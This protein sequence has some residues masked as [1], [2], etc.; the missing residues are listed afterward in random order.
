MGLRYVLSFVVI[1][2]LSTT[3]YGQD[4]GNKFAQ[5]IN[6]F[7]VDW[8]KIL[9][10]E[11]E[12]N[13]L[14]SPVSVGA[15]L[16]IIQQGAKGNSAT[17]LE[18]TL[19]LTGEESQAGFREL[20]TNLKREK[21]RVELEWGSGGYIK[22]DYTVNEE[23]KENVLKNFGVQINDQFPDA[24]EAAA[25]MNEEISNITRG[26][27]KDLFT[28]SN[29]K[30]AAALF[31]NAIYF[32]GKWKSPFP[33]SHTEDNKFY[34]TADNTIDVPF[35]EQTLRTRYGEDS[36][37]GVKW[38]EL[39]YDDREYSMTIILPTERH[40]LNAVINKITDS[41]VTNI[42]NK[43]DKERVYLKMPKFTLSQKESVVGSLKQLGITDIFS[44]QSDL[45]GITST[46]PPLVVSDIIQQVNVDV[47][48]DGSTAA[49]AV[50][51]VVFPLSFEVN[52]DQP[53][54]F[55]I[56]EP[57]L[58]IISQKSDNIPLFVGKVVKPKV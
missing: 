7:T 37:L 35:M 13:V 30:E 4:A 18:S 23:F 42:L 21:F 52:P 19:H 40:G 55:K 45:T 34:V 50:G 3:G 46:T 49:A 32:K 5:S 12:E 6:K 29:L 28:P 44:P 16:G 20:T 48:E 26:V 14:I 54:E 22:K 57:F 2:C 43:Q 9:S 25:R 58:F 27:I 33:R 10:K 39:R 1:V 17:Q 8:L 51:V 56:D 36:N 47:D 24:E 38:L 15:V 31:Y 53:L 11:N 41:D